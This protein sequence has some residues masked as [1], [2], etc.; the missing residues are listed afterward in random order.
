MADE[1][2]LAVIRQGVA[3]WNV[4]R[5]ANLEVQPNFY[6]G[7]LYQVN[8]S[9]AELSGADFSYAH[10]SQ[11]NLTL[12]KLI[13]A[14]LIGADLIWATLSRAKL[15]HADLSGANL[16]R[17]NLSYADFSG[18]TLSRAELDHADL[19][20]A[21]LNH[22]KLSHAKLTHADLSHANLSHANLSHAN[23]S[24]ADLSGADLSNADLSNADLSN[25]NLS[26]AD[27]NHA[28]LNHA[29]LS[30]TNF[31]EA[32][33]IQ[34]DLSET[35]ANRTLFVNVDLGSARQLDT[36]RHY[37]S[38]SVSTDTLIRSRGKIPQV[39]LRGCGVAESLIEYLPSLLGAMQA[40]Q[41]YSCFISYSTHDEEFARRLHGRMQQDG[42]RVWFAS[43]DMKA[44]AKIHEQIDQAIRVHDKLVLV[45]SEQSIRS[46]WVI[47]EIRKARKAELRDERRK[48]FPI[49][50]VDMNTLRNWECFDADSGKDLAVEVRE[51]FLQDFSE[52][53]NHD[54]FEATFA[55]L[56][57]DLKATE[58]LPAPAQ[59]PTS[60]VPATISVSAYA[61]IQSL[62]RTK[63]RRLQI[64]EEQQA[65]KSSNTPQEVLIELQDLRHELAELEKRLEENR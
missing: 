17:T 54:K 36:V 27:L 56:L 30:A 26:N 5:Q 18:A 14:K 55:K 10:L 4:W 51:Y 38:S 22:A 3:I 21:N 58:A 47:T 65:L 19:N 13:S 20:H 23:L 62:I 29:I 37:S 6:N 7:D 46:E 32:T 35:F 48:L 2:H 44:G 64:L 12:A 34:T 63:T 8:L 24:N 11:V 52:W 50:L 31:H 59:A 53:K 33:L 15:D 43:E 45:L 28:D 1:E 41:F 39:F 57:R 9:G 25:A 60:V 16:S 40:I 61:H 42:L 49:R